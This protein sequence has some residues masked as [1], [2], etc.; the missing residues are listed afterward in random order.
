MIT[1]LKLFLSL[2]AFGVGCVLIYRWWLG[3]D[4]PETKP[5]KG[6]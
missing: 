1:F 3:P 5:G 6:S 4:K 2:L